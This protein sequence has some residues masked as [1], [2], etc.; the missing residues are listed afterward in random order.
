MR[1]KVKSRY[2]VERTPGCGP[3]QLGQ[4]SYEYGAWPFVAVMKARL[5]VNSSL[6]VLGL[7]VT[8]CS[9]SS[10]AGRS[11]SSDGTGGNAG[12]GSSSSASGGATTGT[13]GSAGNESGSAGAPTGTGGGSLGIWHGAVASAVTDTMLQEEYDA[14]YRHVVD[15]PD[16]S[17]VVAKD[18]GNIVSEGIG[19]G[20]L[21]AAGMNQQQLFDRLWKHYRDHLDSKG[22]MNWE[23]TLCAPAGNNNANAASDAD[24]DAAMALL[25]AGARWPGGSYLADAEAL[26]AKI[27][28]HEVDDCDGRATL[29]PGDAWGGCNDPSGQTRVNPSYFAPGYYRAFAARFPAQAERWNALVEG[30]YYLY[31]ILQGRMEGLVPDWSNYD[32]ADWYGAGYWY[33]A[34]RTP[35]RVATDYAWSGDPRARGFLENVVVGWLDPKGGLPSAAQ[36]QNSAFVGAFALAGMY[37]QTKLDGYVNGW[38]GAQLDDVPYYQNTLR[39]LYLLLAAGKFESTL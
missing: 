5:V 9:A 38:F 11:G 36:Q 16:G 24:L 14:W 25:Q 20:M 31:P 22:L 12:S 2:F 33:D 35:W 4:L 30:T 28:E 13:G 26:A 32:G 19:Y 10:G 17:S 23:L 6:C 8:A 3:T 29:A 37:D 7:C 39:M 21:I 34:C 1:A 15:C 18:A 27:L